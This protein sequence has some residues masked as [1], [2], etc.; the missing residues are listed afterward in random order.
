[1]RI[2]AQNDTAKRTID[3]VNVLEPRAISPL[4]KRKNGAATPILGAHKKQ[5]Q[6]SF[7][8]DAKEQ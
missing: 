4:L 3:K 5:S 1:M 8:G 6:I 7:N 2:I